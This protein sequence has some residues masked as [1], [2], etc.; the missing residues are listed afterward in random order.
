MVWIGS[1]AG[2]RTEAII[3]DMDA[4]PGR[5]VGNALEVVECV[6]TL[7]GRGPDDVAALVLLLASRV[8]VVSGAYAESDAERAAC[9]ALSSG[10]ALEKMRAMVKWQGGDLRV[11][12]DYS[13]LPRAASRQAVTAN[14]NGYV[15]GLQADLVGRASMVLGAG[16]QRIEDPIDHGADPL[17]VKKPGEW[18]APA[19]QSWSCCT[20]MIAVSAKPRPSRTRRPVCPQRRSLH[21][22]LCSALCP[23]VVSR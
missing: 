4:P 1:Q 9:R 7:K 13:R 15:A 17:V 12:S 6:E 16:R 20:T 22:R 8:M 14:T 21:D 2:L 5:A 3:T 10:A 11:L 23:E 18:S 19:T